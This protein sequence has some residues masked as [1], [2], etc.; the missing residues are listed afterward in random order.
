MARLVRVREHVNPLAIQYQKPTPPP[1]WSAVYQDWSL[2]L[3]LDLGS[4]QGEYLLQ[5]AQKYP[6]RNFLGLE[7]RQPL[8]EYSND[9]RAEL[10]LTN[11]YFLFC[12]INQT[13]P[14]LLPA[15]KKVKEVTIHFPDPWFKRRQHK[16][17]LVNRELV[18][19]LAQ[20]LC[21]T[22]Q[23]LVQSDV[24]DIARSI[25]QQFEAHPDFINLAGAGQFS[26][27]YPD[28]IPTA[29][30]LWAVRRNRPIYRMVFQLDSE[31]KGGIPP[32]S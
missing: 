9:R 26:D 2:P 27:H 28:H 1:D 18:N 32:L 23:V 21:P 4:G 14:Y 24:W 13:L 25:L 3:S 22:G 30:E 20:I 17:R 7:I 15:D 10:G 6:D 31:K 29:R 12:N 5:M 19:T 16:R 11:V 8:V